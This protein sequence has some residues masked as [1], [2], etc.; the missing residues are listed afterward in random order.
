MNF[1]FSVQEFTLLSVVE[2]ITFK[3]TLVG[4]LENYG[5]EDPKLTL[6]L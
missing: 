2:I 1:S 5:K 3:V 6:C 4:K